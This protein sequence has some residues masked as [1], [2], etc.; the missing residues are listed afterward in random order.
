M[1]PIVIKEDDFERRLRVRQGYTDIVSIDSVKFKERY[2]RDHKQSLAWSQ[3]RSEK[4]QN[5]SVID[6]YP[7]VGY[8]S[9]TGRVGVLDGRHRIAE[10]ARRVQRIDVAVDPKYPLPND[11]DPR[12]TNN[13][14]DSN[15]SLSRKV[16]NIVED[17]GYD[18]GV[19]KEA[20]LKFK[21]YYD[22][23][24]NA[25]NGKKSMNRGMTVSKEKDGVLTI[26]YFQE[27]PIEDN[28]FLM[29]GHRITCDP[30]LRDNK[31]TGQISP[32]E[33]FITIRVETPVVP[34]KS[35]MGHFAIIMKEL[36]KD[37][38]IHEYVHYKDFLRSNAR[39]LAYKGKKSTEIS[40][41]AYMNDPMEFNAFYQEAVSQWFDS[42]AKELPRR[43]EWKDSEEVSRFLTYIGLGEGQGFEDFKSKFLY[44][45]RQYGGVT[46]I[47]RKARFKRF[48]S[49]LYQLYQD[50]KE[51]DTTKLL[52]SI[53]A[54]KK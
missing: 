9:E 44:L 53:N 12:P 19:R 11:V 7:K 22:E 27:V 13:S 8:S 5:A 37:S 24:E 32:Y 2:E 35:M 20:E 15:E 23:F 18:T 54:Y 3:H 30:S 47:L 46:K 49:R 21:N 25:M 50:L 39:N 4:L 1:E 38:F 41:A 48:V 10:A 6:S 14:V 17:V 40:T 43:S 45:T 29:V 51:K 16:L 31:A 34:T 33:K 52:W 36:V 26:K 42:A 28:K